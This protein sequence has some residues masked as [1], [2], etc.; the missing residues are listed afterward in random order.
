MQEE[1]PLAPLPLLPLIRRIAGMLL[2][3]LFLS[4]LSFGQLTTYHINSAPDTPL[5]GVNESAYNTYA[6]PSLYMTG[7]TVDLRWNQV[8]AGTVGDC[9]SLNFTTFDTSLATMIADGASSGKYINFIV[10]PVQ[11]GGSN[12]DTPSY[13]F[14][15]A[16]AN[17]LAHSGT[18]AG[19]T[20]PAWS[21]GETVLPGNYILANGHFWQETAQP[22]SSSAPFV[23]TCTTGTTE[24]AFN[25]TTPPYNDGTCTWTEVGTNAPTQDVCFST[26]YHG[27]NVIL[28]DN[29]NNPG[30][31]N[32]NDLPAGATL[33]NLETGFPVSYETPMKVAY[34]YF[35]QQVISHYQ[36]SPPSGLKL[37]YIRFGL[38]EGGETVPLI[39]G[40]WPYFK[41]L[42]GEGPA[43]G[44]SIV[45]L[46]YD[47]EMM[48]FQNA[49]NQTSGSNPPINMQADLNTWNNNTDYP[50][51]EAL[52]AVQNNIGIGTNGLQVADVNAISGSC[53]SSNST[54]SGDWCYNFHQYCSTKMPNGNYP[55]CSLQTFL[56]STPGNNNAVV[57][58][59]PN[60][61][62]LSDEYWNNGTSWANF[63]GL[64]PTAKQYGANNLEIYTCDI[65]YAVMYSFPTNNYPGSSNCGTNGN[66]ASDAYETD[67]V[68]AFRLYL[69][70]TG[71][72]SPV[73]GGPTTSDSTVTLTW[74]AFPGATSYNVQ[75]GSMEGTQN[76]FHNTNTHSG[77]TVHLSP[78]QTTGTDIWVRWTPNNGSYIDYHYVAP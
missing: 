58:G 69:G 74:Y 4:A 45:F 2:P 34:K 21:A 64:I 38:T 68:D 44:A 24:P 15:Q 33:T 11:E 19:V 9:P 62:A 6:L 49:N 14:T 29:G 3:M 23:G 48:E 17:N 10:M 26:F 57:A 59:N 52:Y 78:T 51:Q 8:D 47:D 16:W 70:N 31:F 35:I 66:P 50:D 41:N 25:R 37:G 40:S 63:A 43:S 53:T 42:T 65:L 75:V 5:T 27:D 7:A 18:C 72:Y 54:I 46:S 12:S 55:I 20:S 67:Y 61:G 28:G 39:S 22:W 60:T 77:V 56:L 76:F 73:P 13:V 71:I 30:C 32:I 36:N 1:E